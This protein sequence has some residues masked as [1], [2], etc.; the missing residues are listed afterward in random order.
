[1]CIHTGG[2]CFAL[3]P[4]GWDTPELLRQPV[5]VAVLKVEAVSKDGDA[6]AKDH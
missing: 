1:M 5:V 2:I 6:Q 4:G 3:C